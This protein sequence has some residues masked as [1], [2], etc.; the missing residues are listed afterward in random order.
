MTD[1]HPN[2]YVRWPVLVTATLAATAIGVT[3][4]SMSLSAHSGQP[5][6]GSVSQTTYVE[7]IREIKADLREMSRKLDALILRD[8]ED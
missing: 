4:L 8:N 7:D 5:H 6:S 1:Q 2:G 3:A